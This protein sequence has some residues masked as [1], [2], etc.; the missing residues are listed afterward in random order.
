MIY[1]YVNKVMDG[2]LVFEHDNTMCALWI[3]QILAVYVCTNG[4][5]YLYLQIK[6]PAVFNSTH[7]GWLV[8]HSIY[9]IVQEN[10]VLPV[11]VYSSVITETMMAFQCQFALQLVCWEP[12][13][14]SAEQRRSWYRI[15]GNIFVVMYLRRWLIVALVFAM[16]GHH[17]WI[18]W[19]KLLTL[20]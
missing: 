9:A 11:F 19:C 14:S 20:N 8:I 10:C 2:V 13:T 18:K 16:T 15:F 12:Q 5:F 17:R 1:F 4:W 7:T 3:N 6:V